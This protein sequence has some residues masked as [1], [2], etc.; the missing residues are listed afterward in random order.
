MPTSQST[1]HSTYKPSPSHIKNG[2]SFHIQ[3]GDGS[4]AAGDVYLD[5]IVVGGLEIDTQAIEAATWVSNSMTANQKMDGVP[6]LAFR[7]LNQ[8]QP[9]PQKPFFENILH[10]LA[11]PVFSVDLKHMAPGSYTFGYINHTMYTGTITYVLVSQ[12]GKRILANRCRRLL[13]RSR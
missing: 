3:Y 6:G 4:R 1:G 12:K 8:V 7:E 5:K 10:A 2:S 13:S 9:R 11:Q